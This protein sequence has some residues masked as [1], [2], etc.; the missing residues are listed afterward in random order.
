MIRKKIIEETPELTQRINTELKIVLDLIQATEQ[1]Q[2]CLD[3]AVIDF[4]QSCHLATKN[5]HAFMYLELLQASKLKN[6]KTREVPEP[7]FF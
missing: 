3:S 1:G 7:Y 4:Q 5:N 6:K 2:D